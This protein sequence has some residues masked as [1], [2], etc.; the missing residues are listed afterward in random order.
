M[1]N[2]YANDTKKELYTISKPL[3]DKYHSHLQDAQILYIWRENEKKDKGNIIYGDVRRTNDIM[4]HFTGADF[5]ISVYRYGWDKYLVPEKKVAYMDHFLSHCKVAL[6]KDGFRKEDKF[7]DPI[8]Q[9]IPPD[10]SCFYDVA[11][12]HGAYSEEL[13]V[14]WRIARTPTKAEE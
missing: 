1:G 4:K 6:D 2:Q 14:L 3:L 13:E 9:L 5:L 11:T 12:R 8:W 10:A 7:G